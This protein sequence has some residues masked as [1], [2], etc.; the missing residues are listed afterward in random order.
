VA[1]SLSSASDA[2]RTEWPLHGIAKDISPDTRTINAPAL[3]VAGE[4][5][6]VEPIE[7]LRQNL[8][9]YP[10]GADFAVIPNTGH[11]I[12]A[13]G[14]RRES[15]RASLIRNLARHRIAVSPCVRSAY[16]P[17]PDARITRMISSTVGGSAGK[18]R[19]LLGGAHPARDQASRP[20]TAGD[21]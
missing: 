12:P 10:S 1:D 9:P 17:G 19:P 5:D 13:R 18:P 6:H 2:A 3:V 11:R 21:P 8:V 7:V 14:T 16:G 4:N 15:A 20:A